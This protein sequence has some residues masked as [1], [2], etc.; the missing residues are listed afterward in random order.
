MRNLLLST[1]AALAITA[2]A[3]AF[4]TPLLTIE[5]FDGLTQVGST[6]ISGTGAIGFVGSDANFSDIQVGG[7]GVSILP[8]P[9]LSTTTLEASTGAVAG[10]HVLT[11][12]IF[13]S[14]LTPFTGEQA[15]TGT[16]NALIG[17]P[18]NATETMFVDGLPVVAET[19]TP[20][21]HAFGPVNSFVIGLTSDEEQYVM[22]FT[23]GH[24]SSSGTMQ[25][26]ASVVPEPGTL[27]LLGT[28]LL[29]LGLFLRRGKPT[30]Y[31]GI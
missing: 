4:A 1:A 9:D 5:V 28:A 14:G 24:Q 11:V 21:V 3:P 7:Q 30:V 31:T 20:P 8:N 12:D 19:L 18:G 26:V 23:D 29:G 15:T 2:A 22:D 6:V 27:A 10:T 16:Y 17:A 13:Q 25:F